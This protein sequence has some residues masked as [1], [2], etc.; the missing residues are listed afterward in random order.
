MTDDRLRRDVAAG[1]VLAAR[2]P[3]GEPQGR[4]G[5]VSSGMLAGSSVT[6]WATSPRRR[7]WLR[8]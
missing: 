4:S 8:L 1:G 2:V 5:A 3:A 6:S 7:R